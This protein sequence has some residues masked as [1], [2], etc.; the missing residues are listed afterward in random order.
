MGPDFPLAGQ[1]RR[2]SR[3]L[4]PRLIV[5]P[6]PPH[7][8]FAFLLWPADRDRLGRGDSPARLRHLAAGGRRRP[9]HGA[10]SSAHRLSPHR[11]RL[12]LQERE[13]G[14]RRHRRR[15]GRRDRHARRHL[16]HHQDLG[17]AF[18][19][20]RPAASGR[21]IGD[22]PGPDAGPAAAALAQADA[23]A[24]GN[25]RRPER[26]EGKRLHQEH[27]PVQLPLG[28]VPR[29]RR[30]VARAADHQSGRIP[31]LSVAEDADRDGARSRVVHHR[32]VAAGPGQDRR[33]RRDRRNRQ[34]ARQDQ[35]PDHLALDH[36]AGRHRH[37]AHG[38]GKPRG[39]KLRPLRL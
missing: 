8:L 28:P 3:R 6:E 2:L 27:R 4:Y 15:R 12:D 14:R 16:R 17:R 31:P 5:P 10:R 34:G 26:G 23:R 36:P 7:A 1:W 33:R 18:P 29:G 39:R 24:G 21:G 32:L 19:A 30:P 22:Q 25:H 11:H 13:G 38:Q 37:S 9:P 20:R 35:R